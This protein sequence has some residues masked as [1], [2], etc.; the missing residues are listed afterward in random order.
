MGY[1][2]VVAYGMLLMRA[3]ARTK[4]P[5]PASHF[6][7][8]TQLECLRAISKRVK[9]SG[10]PTVTEAFQA[11]A[12]LG[13]H[14]KRNGPP[15]WQTLSRGYTSLLAYEQGYLAALKDHPRSPE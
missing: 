14:L 13:G 11:C 10:K 6:F 3:L 2:L 5:V 1:C 15:G 9:L 4:E 8:K 12:G 7:S